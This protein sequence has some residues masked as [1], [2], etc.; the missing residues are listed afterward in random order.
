MNLKWE[1]GN[2]K[3][4]EKRKLS[5]LGQLHAIRPTRSFQRAGPTAF[6]C[7][8]ST[9]DARAPPVNLS[10]HGQPL[11]NRAPT[12]RPPRSVLSLFSPTNPRFTWSPFH[13]IRRRFRLSARPH[14]SCA[15]LA[16]PAHLPLWPVAKRRNYPAESAGASSA[17]RPWPLWPTW[18]RPSP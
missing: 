1:K 5:Q 17:R 7:A 12:S 4:K 16:G 6:R 8:C 11:S 3:L 13:Q 15:I 9:T 14:F 18:G 10:A 2:G